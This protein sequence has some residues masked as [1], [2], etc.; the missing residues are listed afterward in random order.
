MAD[1]DTRLQ[2]GDAAPS[3]DLFNQDGE[4]RSLTDLRG[5]PVVVYFFPKAFT[6]GCTAE[7]CDFR[8]SKDA[9]AAAGYT[10]LGVSADPPSTLR[11]FA[12]THQ[13]NHDLLSDPNYRAA[14]AW[15]A[16]GT[17][18]VNGESKVGALRSTFVVDATGRLEAVEYGVDPSGHVAELNGRL[19]AG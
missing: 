6:P 1:A 11:D 8:D 10:V 18:V 3:L 17:K 7:V 5:R 16:W 19:S 15:G 9:L 4:R 14:R 2:V 13:V 12:D